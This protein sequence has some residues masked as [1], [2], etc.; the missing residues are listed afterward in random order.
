MPSYDSVPHEHGDKGVKCGESTYS[1]ERGTWR[2]MAAP[3]CS[4]TGACEQPREF[5][6]TVCGVT[7][8]PFSRHKGNQRPKCL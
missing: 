1:K 6:V 7:V 2:K 5:Q 8:C 3:S 4:M